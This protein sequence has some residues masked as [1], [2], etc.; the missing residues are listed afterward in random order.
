MYR[1]VARKVVKIVARIVWR[2]YYTCEKKSRK[3]TGCR[4][5]L[6]NLSGRI[7]LWGQNFVSKPFLAKTNRIYLKS[8]DRIW[9]DSHVDFRRIK[10]GHSY[11]QCEFPIYPLLWIFIHLCIFIHFYRSLWNQVILALAL[12]TYLPTYL[13]S[14]LSLITPRKKRLK[15][16]K[17]KIEKVITDRGKDGTVKMHWQITFRYY[18]DRL[19]TQMLCNSQLLWNFLDSVVPLQ[20]LAHCMLWP[21]FWTQGHKMLCIGT[22]GPKLAIQHQKLQY[23]QDHKWRHFRIIKSVRILVIVVVVFVVAVVVPAVVVYTS[24]FY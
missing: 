21:W 10:F 13:S 6:Q 7:N 12:P 1:L 11:P 3:G 17:K 8:F 14:W 9:R 16:K 5:A 2:R 24:E 15:R 20:N 19:G 23:H 4:E 18:L 22:I